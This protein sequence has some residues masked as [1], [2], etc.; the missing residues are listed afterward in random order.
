MTI[1]MQAKAPQALLGP[2][3]ASLNTHGGAGPAA[4][5]PVPKSAKPN[6]ANVA[7]RSP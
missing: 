4:L 1:N 6:V 7:L 2:E 3:R 5:F